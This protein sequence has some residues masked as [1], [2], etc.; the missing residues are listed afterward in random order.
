M[1]I[2]RD[3][4][5]L[6]LNPTVNDVALLKDL[7]TSIPSEEME[8]T[9][10]SDRVNSPRYNSPDN[11]RPVLGLGRNLVLALNIFDHVRYPKRTVIICNRVCLT[12]A[13]TH[14]LFNYVT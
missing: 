4:E 11:I 9:N 5:D 14:L 6:W 2:L 7:L 12:P 3:K 8:I 1:I 10:V 13:D